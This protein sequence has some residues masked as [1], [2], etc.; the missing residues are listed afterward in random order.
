MNMENEEYDIEIDFDEIEQPVQSNAEPENQISTDSVQ[1]IRTPGQVP[2]DFLD[3]LAQT[4]EEVYKKLY[5]FAMDSFLF[6]V[7][8][9]DW[10][11]KSKSGFWHTQLQEIYEI[12]EEFGDTLCETTMAYTEDGI[13]F[14]TKQ[15]QL[16]DEQFIDENVLRKITEYR[17]AAVNISKNLE[18]NRSIASVFDDMLAKLDKSIGLMKNFK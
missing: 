1:Q 13:H 14:N 18:I 6:T 2:V 8:V 12:I 5:D 3:F 9:R 4:R 7:K 11:F 15:F 10:H 16:N 17:D